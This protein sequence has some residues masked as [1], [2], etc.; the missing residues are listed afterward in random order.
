[1]EKSITLL[2]RKR[3]DKSYWRGTQID[4]LLGLNFIKNKGKRT[5]KNNRLERENNE[6]GNFVMFGEP[7]IT[8]E[9]TFDQIVQNTHIYF[10]FNNGLL[11]S[12]KN[13]S[14]KLMR[15]LADYESGI[16]IPRFGVIPVFLVGQ[17]F[18]FAHSNILIFDFKNKTCERFE[19]YGYS[20]EDKDFDKKMTKVLTV[21]K[22]KYQKPLKDADFQESEEHQISVSAKT[23]KKIS[24][25]PGG[26]CAAWC[27]WYVQL[28]L[29]FPKL[30]REQLIDKINKELKKLETSER[31]LIRNYANYL[32]R[33]RGKILEDK[34]LG[35]ERSRFS[36]IEQLQTLYN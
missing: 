16:K 8:S 14:S 33:A 10:N 7:E 24:S 36:K 9:Y 12:P 11:T 34:G 5:K 4:I 19:P 23:A 18:T 15:C 30:T 20:S 2:R 35:K 17:Q 13:F 22:L 29:K 32:I 21:F 25:D 31:T 27:I 28:R 6:T 1:M 26:Y 3:V